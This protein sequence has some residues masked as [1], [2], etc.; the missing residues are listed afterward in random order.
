MKF[1][2]CATYRAQASYLF[3]VHGGGLARPRVIP[4]PRRR[5]GTSQFAADHASVH[6][7][8][9]AA[10]IIVLSQS[11]RFCVILRFAQ[12]DILACYR[13]GII[14]KRIPLKYSVSGIVGRTG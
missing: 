6:H 11:N 9:A 3:S 5:L 1:F 14:S 4:S 12:D 2:S 10:T 8:L 7:V 13:P